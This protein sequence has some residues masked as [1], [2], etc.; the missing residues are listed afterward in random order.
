MPTFNRPADCVATLT[1]IASDPE[2]LATVTAV[3]LPDQGTQ[4][5]RDAAGF[6]AAADAL[7]DKL[8]IID[9]PN[10][11][12]SGGYARIMY[13]ALETTDADWAEDGI[14]PGSIAGLVQLFEQWNTELRNASP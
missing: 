6:A 1:A 4:K 13:E 5:V 12:G 2:V 9:Q 8:R 10:L 7:G 14:E 11:G 3:I